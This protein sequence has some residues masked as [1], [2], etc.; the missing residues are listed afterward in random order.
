MEVNLGRFVGF[1][2]G[3]YKSLFIMTPTF[4]IKFDARFSGESRT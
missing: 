1:L 4:S 2:A 3:K